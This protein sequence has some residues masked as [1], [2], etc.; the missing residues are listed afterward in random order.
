MKLLL[1]SHGSF[2]DG[3]K[4]SY[5]M[6]VGDDSNLFSVNLADDGIGPFTKK[7]HSL[8]DELTETEQVLVLT[9]VKG[10]TPFNVALAYQLENPNKIAVVSGMNLPML[11]EIGM[12]VEYEDNLEDLSISAI[13]IGKEGI[14]RS[15]FLGDESLDDDFEL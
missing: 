2:V 9:D 7:V 3:I 12:Q 4:D 15:D 8:L 13:E 11:M 14:S 5:R 10:G 6:I 1:L